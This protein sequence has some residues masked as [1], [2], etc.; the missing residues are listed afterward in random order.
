M[1][2]I[3]NFSLATDASVWRVAEQTVQLL[4]HMYITYAD[5]VYT[6]TLWRLHLCCLLPVKSFAVDTT[7]QHSQHTLDVSCS[8]S[9]LTEIA[10]RLAG[11]EGKQMPVLV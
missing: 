3:A 7:A 5:A 6:L 9:S 4:R 1:T 11:G 8:G 10:A 2:A